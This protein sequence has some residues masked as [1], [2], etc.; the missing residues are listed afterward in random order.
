MLFTLS[1]ISSLVEAAQVLV[2]LFSVTPTKLVNPFNPRASSPMYTCSSLS[3]CHLSCI[4][5]YFWV[6]I[7]RPTCC[8][9]ASST[10]V[11]PNSMPHRF[12]G[13]PSLSIFAFTPAMAVESLPIQFL[14]FGFAPVPAAPKLVFVQLEMSSAIETSSRSWISRLQVYPTSGKFSVWSRRSSS[15]M[16]NTPELSTVA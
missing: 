2:A 6:S 7:G 13:L 15:P 10:T 9:A 8:A 1:R 4:P 14:P 3:I 5:S 11:Q 12:S 16:R